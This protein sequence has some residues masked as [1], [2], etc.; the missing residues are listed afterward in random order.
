MRLFSKN[1]S[2]NNYIM[3]HFLAFFLLMPVLFASCIKDRI[4]PAAQPIVAPH[5]DT[6]MYYWNFNDQDSS[7][8][9]AT[10]GVHSGAYFSY[11]CAYIDYTTGT[12]IN[13]ITANDS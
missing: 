6:L 2:S 13:A 10:F 11:Y 9:N 7:D 5:G 12:P 8:H 3:K 4:Q 1:Q